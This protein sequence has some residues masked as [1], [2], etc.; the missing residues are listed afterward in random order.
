MK[1]GTEGLTYR[2]T[3]KFYENRWESTEYQH[4]LLSF[5]RETSGLRSTANQGPL[6]TIHICVQENALR[7]VASYLPHNPLAVQVIHRQVNSLVFLSRRMVVKAAANLHIMSASLPTSCQSFPALPSPSCCAV[8]K[9]LGSIKGAR[10]GQ[11]ACA[12]S[13]K[14]SR[15]TSPIPFISFNAARIWLGEESVC[16]RMLLRSPPADSVRAF[17]FF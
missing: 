17:E 3:P 15:P 2:C 12:V 11:T 6:L 16:L 7:V 1:K 10:Q 9:L 4:T 14:M 8:F 5:R 13:Q